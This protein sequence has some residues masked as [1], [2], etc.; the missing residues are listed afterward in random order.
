MYKP[1]AA[2]KPSSLHQTFARTMADLLAA[3]DD[4]GDQLATE[5]SAMTNPEP[6]DSS[7]TD[8]QRSVVE[9]TIQVKGEDNRAE[10]CSCR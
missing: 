3:V 9:D 1:G 6:D 7:E 4:M 8:E 5:L 2:M 10:I